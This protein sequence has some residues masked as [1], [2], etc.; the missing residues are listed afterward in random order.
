MVAK[1]ENVIMRCYS[2]I[3]KDEWKSYIENELF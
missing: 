2:Q 1:I 3:N